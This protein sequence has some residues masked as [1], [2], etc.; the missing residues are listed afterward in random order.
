MDTRNLRAAQA[1][2]IAAALLALTAAVGACGPLEEKM[3][4]AASVSRSTI[5]AL[6]A[7]IPAHVETATFALG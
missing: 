3:P 5:P 2:T 6:D 4:P 7:A 1:L